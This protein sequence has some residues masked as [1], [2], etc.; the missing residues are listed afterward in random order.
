[1]CYEFEGTQEPKHSSWL[2]NICVR[3]LVYV[4]VHMHYVLI[5]PR[6]THTHTRTHKHTH[7]LQHM[8]L[9]MYIHTYVHTCYVLTN[10]PIPSSRC[11]CFVF[12]RPV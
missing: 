7:T 10:P 4:C 12:L 5:N 8:Y 3:V 1:M 11:K 6:Y 2:V 9:C